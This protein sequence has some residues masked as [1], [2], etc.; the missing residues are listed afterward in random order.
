MPSLRGQDNKGEAAGHHT[1]LCWGVGPG[2]NPIPPPSLGLSPQSSGDATSLWARCHCTS[3]RPFMVWLASDVSSLGVAMGDI[4]QP[5]S[6]EHRDSLG[7]QNSSISL[8]SSSLAKTCSPHTFLC[9]L[10]AF[11]RTEAPRPP[12]AKDLHGNYLL[13]P[14]PHW[15]QVES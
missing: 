2:R 7:T 6:A 8:S 4:Q 5:R 10:P 11:E 12:S 9:C 15:P 1:A 14:I 13:H 3:F